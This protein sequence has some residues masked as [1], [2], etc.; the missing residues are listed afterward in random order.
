M[1]QYYISIFILFIII[2]IWEV[3]KEFNN[4]PILWI[5]AINKLNI[6]KKEIVWP[7]FFGRLF[8]FLY[9]SFNNNYNIYISWYGSYFPF[10]FYFL[11]PDY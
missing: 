9:L 11:W 7:R 1:G 8:P 5:L 4:L 6:K 10:Y 3:E 2:I